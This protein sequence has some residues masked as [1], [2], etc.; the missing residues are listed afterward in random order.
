MPK[1]F[2]RGVALGGLLGGL[3]VWMHTSPKGKQ[4]KKQIE[5]RLATLWKRIEREYVK[6]NPDGV[7]GL[8]RDMKSAIK[9]WQEKDVTTDVKKAL[10][11][12]TKK[13]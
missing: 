7:A 6:A 10:R 12:F 8:K 5:D 4:T 9:T 2:V 11:S 3:L 1:R 13:M